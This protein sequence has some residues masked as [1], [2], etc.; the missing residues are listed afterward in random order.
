MGSR[1]LRT[2]QECEDFIRGLTF[3]G[4]GGGGDPKRGLDLLLAELEA[5]REVGWVDMAELPDEA[6]TAIVA[7]LGGRPPKE[8]PSAEE[9]A[10]IGLVEPRPEN[11]LV[12]A[13][14]E[15]A[16]YAGVE[17]E[18]IMPGEIG[19]G[20]VPAPLAVARQLGVLAIDGDYAGGRAIPELGQTIPEVYGKPLFPMATVDRWGNICIVKE[21]VSTAMADRIGR[22][23]AV[24]AFGGIAFAAYLMPAREAK[25]VMIQG[26]LTQAY[27]VG[28]ALREAVEKG[29]DPAEEVARFI[30]GW[31]LFRGEV[32]ETEWEDKE[33]YMFG[34]GTHHLQGLGEDAGHT[35]RIWYKNEFHITWRDDQPFV[36]SPDSIAVIEEETGE[37]CT[38]YSMAEGQKVAVIGRKGAEAHRTE[39]GLEVLGPRHFGFDIEYVPI[40]EQVA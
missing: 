40:E 6:W 9:M 27:Q 35:F 38:N 15:L 39:R 22:M 4:T 29:L 1:T 34:Y 17:L 12:V 13:V 20:N 31:L 24:A 21:A 19:A 10:R 14:Q 5:G 26:T 30:G 23:L 7:G 11:P 3:L 25:E 28:R 18:A 33:P 8:G 16:A 37:P 2:R 36:T 32:T